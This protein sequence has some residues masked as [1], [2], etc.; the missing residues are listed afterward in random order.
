M[1]ADEMQG[2]DELFS[3]YSSYSVVRGAGRTC[4]MPYCNNAS[5]IREHIGTSTLHKG[6]Q[7][8]SI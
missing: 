2:E 5:G 3:M 4:L 6:W 8:G 7:Y 1:C